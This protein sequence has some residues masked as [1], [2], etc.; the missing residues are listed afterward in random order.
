MDK[1]RRTTSSLGCLH[2]QYKIIR[3]QLIAICIN[4]WTRANHIKAG[5]LLWLIPAATRLTNAKVKHCIELESYTLI[6][7]GIVL[8]NGRMTSAY[9]VGSVVKK[10]LRYHSG[11]SL[12][13]YRA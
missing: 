4:A 5:L 9:E 1:A 13:E 6:I 2:C 11:V 7:Y 3:G 8:R 12:Y 10:G